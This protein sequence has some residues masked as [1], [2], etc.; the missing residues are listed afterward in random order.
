[1]GLLRSYLGIKDSAGEIYQRAEGSCGW[2]NDRQDFQEWRDSGALNDPQEAS[3]PVKNPSIFW[4]H[5]NP[6]TGK[7]FLASHVENQLVDLQVECAS[8][9]FHNGNKSSNLG[10]LLRSIAYQMAGSNAL[11][12]ESL[13]ALQK[14]E[15]AFDPDNEAT[16]WTKI[17]KKGIFLVSVLIVIC[18][19]TTMLTDLMQVPDTDCTILGHRRH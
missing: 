16:I 10:H 4:V 1:M 13:I 19:R 17:F 12:R 5:A 14:E 6:G 2:I 8:Y 9:F 3:T 15:M 11:I 18:P 7:T